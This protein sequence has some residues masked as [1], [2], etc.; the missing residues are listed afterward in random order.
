VQRYREGFIFRRW[1]RPR[2]HRQHPRGPGV[3]D[4]LVPP[5]GYRWAH[6]HLLPPQRTLAGS[7]APLLLPSG[8]HIEGEDQL[9]HLSAPVPAPALHAD[10]SH[11]T[12]HTRGRSTIAS[13]APSHTH[14]GAATACSMAGCTYGASLG[15]AGGIRVSETAWLG[16]WRLGLVSQVMQQHRVELPR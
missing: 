4:V 12:W 10:D 2:T 11:D 9:P 16:W 3:A 13:Q 5:I 1:C 7:L 6:G 14:S 15:V 8:I